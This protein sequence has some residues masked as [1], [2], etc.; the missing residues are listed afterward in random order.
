LLDTHLSVTD[1]ENLDLDDESVLRWIAPQ[2]KLSARELNK[3][4]LERQWERI[5]EQ[6]RLADGIGVP[7]IRRLAETC[8]AHLAAAAS[9]EPKPYHGPAVL[10]QADAGPSGVD[11][12]WNSLCPRLCVERVPGNHYSMLRAPDVAVLAERV[13]RYLV[14]QVG[15]LLRP[16]QIGNLPHGEGE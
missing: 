11:P 13:D 15:N 7:E 2:L 16:G 5:A 12:R 6:A 10:F 3:L 14:E 4:P 9:Y 1:Y 8:K